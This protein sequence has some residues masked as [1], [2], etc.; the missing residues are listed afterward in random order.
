MPFEVIFLD[1]DM[2]YIN[3]IE[4]ADSIRT[5]NSNM[6]IIFV[7]N[8]E[9]LV[10]KSIKYS[11]FRFI[12]K[13]NL[14]DD[15]QELFVALEEKINFDSMEYAVIVNGR[16]KYLSVSNILY[17]ESFRHEIVAHYCDGTTYDT[18]ENL[19]ILAKKF[20]KHGFIRV[21]RSY[22]VNYRN[23]YVINQ[24]DLKLD[25]GE[26]IPISRLKRQEILAKYQ[27]FLRR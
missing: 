3:G 7:T 23:I 1:I 11:P 2:P 18:K 15:I 26:I 22:L 21:H 12:R 17:F 19:S 8:K 9:N 16:T 27:V 25:T 6:V 20:E 5:I 10:F 13:S 24:V 4:V 14:D